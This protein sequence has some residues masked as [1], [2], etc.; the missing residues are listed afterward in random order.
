MDKQIRDPGGIHVVKHL[1]V[2]RHVW[3]FVAETLAEMPG[4]FNLPGHG[5]VFEEVLDD[6]EIAV[7]AAGKTRAAHADGDLREIASVHGAGFLG[8][9]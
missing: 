2:D 4:Q 9:S 3:T 7:V 8:V 1:P 6:L 5:P